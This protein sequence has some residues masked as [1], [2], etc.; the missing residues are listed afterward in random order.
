[1][2]SASVER[3][4]FVGGRLRGLDA[5]A[6]LMVPGVREVFEIPSGVAVLADDTAAALAG[7]AALH[8]DWSPGEPLDSASI[9]ARLD[10]ALDRP[11][12]PARDDG[13]ALG[14]LR[15][16]VRT[17]EAVYHT[18]Y[19]AHA[20]LEP[21]NCTARVADGACDLWLGTQAQ[22]ATRKAAARV[23]GVP[24][25]RVR[26]HQR[27]L[28]GGFGRRGDTDFVE[29]AVAIARRVE[30]PVQLLWTRAD[31]M[32]HD[33]FRPANASRLRA[34]LGSDGM[35]VAWHQRVA[36]PSLALDGVRI[37]YSIP[38]VRVELVR[39]DPGVPTGAW[40]SVGASQN[41]FAVESFVDE[42]AE[43]AGRDPF[44][45]REGLLA[46]EPRMQAVLRLAAE[47]AGWGSAGNGV[48]RGIAFCHSFGSSVAQVVEVERS[49]DDPP[50][51]V[52]RVVCA[53]DC[54]T[55]V[56]PDL[57]HAQME[58]AVVFALSAALRGQITLKNGQVQ[59]SSFE[60]YPI[61]TLADTP[62]IEVH[63]VDSREPPGGVGEP[64]VPPLAPALANALFAATG[65]RVRELPL[66]SGT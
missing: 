49:G 16:A 1:M 12:E 40:R 66:F 25:S 54:G 41:T 59:Q 64:G 60:D 2:R 22:T 3:C 20:C 13:D 39:E 18:P 28:G 62:E 43:A 37:P 63:L 14:A 33:R 36:G 10:R 48:C 38:H 5:A 45:Y 50:V 24:E 55:V 42:L 7:R 51:R 65:R 35:P 21:M 23:A 31:D 46:R 30:G 52:R 32:R 27:F 4:P 29:E 53:L 44:E 57:V 8:V 19:L 56:D 15:G 11:V 6:A 61:L 9:R 26:V 47:R 17:L 34:A 58:G